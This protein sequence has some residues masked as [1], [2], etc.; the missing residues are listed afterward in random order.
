MVAAKNPNNRNT[1]ISAMM[2]SFGIVFSI[3]MERHLPSMTDA[4]I[5]LDQKHIGMLPITRQ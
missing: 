1:G 2:V 3:A 4:R 5:D